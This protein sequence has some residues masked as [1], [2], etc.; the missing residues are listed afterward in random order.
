M[1]LPVRWYGMD[2]PETHNR[3]NVR[4]RPYGAGAAGFLAPLVR[5]TPDR[6]D[7]DGDERPPAY[8]RHVGIRRSASIDFGTRRGEYLWRDHGPQW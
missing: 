8:R 7:T 3:T 6:T 4:G 1:V 2:A 5:H